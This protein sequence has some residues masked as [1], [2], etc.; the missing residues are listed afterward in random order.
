M[1]KHSIGEFEE[2]VM[3]TVAILYNNAYG[4]SIKESIETRLN[5]SVSVGAMRTALSRLENKGFLDSEFGEATAVRGGKRKRY[6]KVTPY[7][8]KVLEQVMQDRKQLW[9][10]ISPLAFDFKFQ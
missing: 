6:F 9:E 8:K 5:R 1:G 10:A 2:V 4:I 3:L 7:G